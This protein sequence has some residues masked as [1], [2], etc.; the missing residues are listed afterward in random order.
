MNPDP[1]L[2]SKGAAKFQQPKLVPP[3][4][5][6]PA[7]AP[8]VLQATVPI[9]AP[10][11]LSP[12]PTPL[13][14]ADVPVIWNVGDV[15]LDTY[16][17]KKLSET[18]DYAEGGFG[19]VYRV[20]H[21][22][23]N[24][25]LAVKSP[26]PQ[27]F[28]NE[29][30][31]ENFERECEAWIDLGLHPHIV[32]CHYVRR[33]GGIPRVFAEYMDGG[34]LSDWIGH[35]EDEV[36]RLY[37]GGHEEALKRML[38]IAIQFAWGLHYA[39]DKGLIHQDVKPSNLMMTADGTAKASDFGLARARA[40]SGED[41]P[42]PADHSILATYGGMTPAFCSPE[43]AQAGAEAKAGLSP[44]RRTKLTR[45]TD[46]W[47]WAVSVLETY[48]GGVTW[49]A[50]QIANE[51]L[52]A[53]QEMGPSDDR[54]PRMPDI[55]YQLLEQCLCVQPEGRPA[56]FREIAQQL[57]AINQATT[58]EPFPRPES[59]AAE[60]LADGLNNKALSMLDLGKSD[61]AEKLWDEALTVEPHHL[62]ATYNRGLVRWRS[63]RLT[64][65][66]LVREMEEARTSHQVQSV[67]QYLLSLVHLER[68]DPEVAVKLLE[69]DVS[70][71]ANGQSQAILA[72]ARRGIEER[73]GCVRTFDGHTSSVASIC[74]NPDGRRALSGGLDKALRLWDVSTGQCIRTFEQLA[75][76][77]NSVC[78]SPDG[79]LAL[80]GGDDKNVRLWDVAAG[81]CI[82][83][84]EGHEDKVKSVCFSPDGRWALSGSED[85]TL[86]LWNLSAGRCIRTLEGH[87][88]AVWSVCFSPHGDVALSGSVD[89]GLRLWDVSTG[90]C[91]QLLTGPTHGITSVCF[92]TDG[93]WALSGS[94]DSKVWLWETSTG[95][96]VRRF[97]GHAGVVTTVCFGPDGRFAISGSMDKTLRLWDISTGQC[98]R[99][100]GHAYTPYTTCFSPDGNW[101]LS[102]GMG[103]TVYQWQITYAKRR[104]PFAVTRPATATDTIAAKRE[105]DTRVQRA[106]ELFQ[107]GQFAAA[108]EH[109]RA[110]RVVSG[111]QRAP[112][113]L[114]L[115][116]AL[117]AHTR[118]TGVLGAWA[119]RTLEEHTACGYSVSFSHDGRWA[120]SGS[121]D[122][123][124][125]LWE[126]S[127]GNCIRSFQGV[128][129]CFGLS[130]NGRWA[131]TWSVDKTLQLWEVST[132]LS[133]RT[134][135]DNTSIN[136]ACFSPDSRSVL[137]GGFDEALR[138]WEVSSGR[139]IGTFG[140]HESMV[141]S[142]CFSPDGRCAL[143]GSDRKLRLWDVWTGRCIRTFEGDN[144]FIKSVC[145]SPDGLW[146]LSGDDGNAVRLWAVSTGKCVR[147][148]KGHT[149][150]VQSVCFSSDG[151]WILSSGDKTLRLWD[152]SNGRCVRTLEGH[153]DYVWDSC[154]SPN[155]QL[156][157]SVSSDETL[158]MWEFDWDL[159]VRSASDW[160][161][162]ALPYLE[163]FLTLRTGGPTAALLPRSMIRKLF[164]AAFARR[165]TPTWT[166][167]DFRGLLLKLGRVGYGWLRPEGV[168]KKLEDMAAN[169]TGPPP[170]PRLENSTP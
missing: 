102:G 170:L 110:A 71:Q 97:E 12:E 10:A 2:A 134:F 139:C 104:G 129:K 116:N 154:F 19:R 28:S 57:I 6:A 31:K 38:D 156:A 4:A 87:A 53:Y 146:A 61:E 32:S 148:F 55:L 107:A 64:D 166:K 162:G 22:A 159:E 60:L 130:P 39:H 85:Q 161:D 144:G 168:R 74:V 143:S 30:Q 119:V 163:H 133:I 40:V 90:R 88:G 54:I 77:I 33:L 17:V 16:E 150:T 160:D 7:V 52:K 45:K 5:Q 43:Q 83:T 78:F 99:T 66:A 50:G 72:T 105:V 51:A 13:A 122:K 91:V 112:D 121:S 153:T 14:E 89:K 81:R 138:L 84:F 42:A 1:E 35:E 151:R 167:E 137:V 126:V 94:G 70:S 103:R 26:L 65:D 149:G 114:E 37:E 145:F 123:N 108:L 24:L 92:S 47:S 67:C 82:Q 79:S 34:S 141:A 109:L 73:T 59:Q 155:G 115:W 118:R 101:A 131:L 8:T 11:D 36:R 135:A 86:R 106:Q 56:D 44:E 132:G 63:G 165:G 111:H 147:T 98:F 128:V 68:N 93:H 49:Q 48:T 9:A 117:G 76:K 15:I 23:W 113:V 124:A 96:C 100:L 25:D 27:Y 158:R 41:K 75:D 69:E 18:K 46:I 21:K 169:W 142:V 120:L 164:I 80:S 3:S 62:Q 136:S 152:V 58:G 20:Y 127:T 95:R 157:L 29:Q 140:R 125:R